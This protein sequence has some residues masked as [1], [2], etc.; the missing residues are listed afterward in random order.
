MKK[1]LI[2]V[3]IIGAVAAIVFGA[4]TAYFSDTETSTGNTITT[5]SVDIEIG[6][7]DESWEGHFELTDMKPSYSD[8]TE[9]RI[10]NTGDNPVNIWKKITNIETDDGDIVEPECEYGGGF[11]DE[12]AADDEE[13]CA[14]GCGGEG[15]CYQ[16]KHD[17]YKY[18]NYDLAVEVH[19]SGG[20]DPLWWQVIYRDADN[21]TV[22][23]VYGYPG[24]KKVLLG[25][26]PAGGY[27][28]VEQS[29]H[30]RGNVGNWAQEDVMSF[31]MEII[32]E[33]LN[34]TVV[35]DDK[36]DANGQPGDVYLTPGNGTTATLNYKVKDKDFKFDFHA[37]G[38]ESSTEYTLVAGLNPYEHPESAVEIGTWTAS[39]DVIDEEGVVD[40]DQDL[41][42]AKVWLILASD[43]GDSG[44]TDWHGGDYLFET[45]LIDYYD[46]DLD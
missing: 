41:I 3:A 37:E 9:L 22:K 10:Y 20:G 11:W 38:L 31:D 26:I 13:G 45:S 33:Q 40:F 4:T 43:W 39:S 35:L 29:Y 44:M 1:I 46:T 32:G 14:I 23:N 25:M 24:H 17:L 30:L 15:Y 6:S 12:N 36:V 34:G 19:E 8:Y 28:I 21:K 42:N 18:I 16:A 2:S 7:E 27:M 5:G